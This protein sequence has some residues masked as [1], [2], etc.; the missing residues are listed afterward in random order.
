LGDGYKWA[1]RDWFL[2]LTVTWNEG[3]NRACGDPAEMS[4]AQ[5]L[6][7]RKVAIALDDPES[8]TNWIGRQHARRDRGVGANDGGISDDLDPFVMGP[9]HVR[10]LR[11]R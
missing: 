11:R 1:R 2:A 5:V 8:V 7:P 9:A 4:A 3:R 10:R 6:D